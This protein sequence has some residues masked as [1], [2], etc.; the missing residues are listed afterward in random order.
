MQQFLPNTYP[1]RC[2]ESVSVVSDRI[3]ILDVERQLAA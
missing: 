2:R 3:R 1:G